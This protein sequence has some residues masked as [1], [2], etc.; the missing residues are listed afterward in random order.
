E[1]FFDIPV[2][3][4]EAQPMMCEEEWENF[5]SQLGKV[6]VVSPD[7]GGVGRADKFRVALDK[8]R[9]GNSVGM[10]VM[11]KR[12]KKAN[13]VKSMDLVGQVQDTDCIIVDD[14]IDTAGTLVTAAEVLKQNGANRIFACATHALLN[15]P[16]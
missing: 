16:A 12:R 6:T 8:L 7:A 3:N 15:D 10:A 13:E 11:S 9:S 14:M 2:D 5:F 1:G 4:L